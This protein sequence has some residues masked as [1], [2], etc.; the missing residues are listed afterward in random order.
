M[1]FSAL[2]VVALVLASGIAFAYGEPCAD[3]TKYGQCSTKSP[4]LYCTGTPPI[5]Q[6]YVAL[7]PCEKVNGYLQQGTGDSATCVQALC[8]DGTK[9]GECAKT[10]PNVCVGGEMYAPNAT[11]CGCPSGKRV[12]SGGVFCEFIPCD[13]NGETVNEGAC[14]VK[15][16]KSCFGGVMV[17]NASCGCPIGT[18][19]VGDKCSM[20]CSDGTIDGSCS[21]T[22]PK[23]CVAGDLVYDADLCGCPEG[24]TKIG[25][26]CAANALDMLGSGTDLLT[27]ANG[28]GNQNANGN[29]T[30]A[31]GLGAGA[32]TTPLSC[33]CLPTALIGIIGGFVAFGKGK[34]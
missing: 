7:C 18:T 30:P 34:D 9:N 31:G 13:Y 17:D 11:K 8:G 28:N 24:Q 25:K 16:G 15:K 21:A 4:G 27:G 10:K 14:S 1:K 12:S 33:C 29:A 3:G 26:Q 20:L 6:P 19:K 2:I 23:K 32:G 22:K 5:L